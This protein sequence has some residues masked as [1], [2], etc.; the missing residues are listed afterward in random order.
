[1][2]PFLL[3]YLVDDV[4]R[5]AL[6]AMSKAYDHSAELALSFV[7]DQL[8]FSGADNIKQCT[9]FARCVRIRVHIICQA[10]VRR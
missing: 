8:G 3:D 6:A 1:M 4:R 9:K 2:G 5:D 7:A 10:C